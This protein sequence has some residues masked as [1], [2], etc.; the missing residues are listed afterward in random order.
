MRPWSRTTR[1]IRRFSAEEVTTTSER[2][3]PSGSHAI[4]SRAVETIWRKVRLYY[5]LGLH[6]AIARCIRHRG[7]VILD[8]AIGHARGNGPNE[9]TSA[10][11]VL[12]TPDT[13]FNIFS[14]TKPVTAMLAL[15]LVERGELSLDDRVADFIDGFERHGKQGVRIRHLLNHRAGLWRTP[16]HCAN[17]Q[18]LPHWNKIVE[19]MRDLKPESPPG[20]ELAYHA[21]TAGFILAE[22]IQQVTGKSLRTSLHTEIRKPLGFNSCTFGVE[23][24]SL[25]DVAVDSVTGPRTPHAISRILTESLGVDLPGLARV[26]N[27]PRY[28]T[29]VVPSGNLMSTPNEACRFFECLRRGGELDG[30]RVFRPDTVRLATRAQ[31]HRELDR[32]IRFP[33]RYGLGFMLGDEPFSLYGHETPHA[34]GHLGFSQILLWCDPER[35]LSVAFINTGKP[36]FTL[37]FV[38]WRDI[39]NTIAAEIPRSRRLR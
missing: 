30:T 36:L 22:V 23:E 18:I 32:V 34:F 11:R 21:L 39:L 25:S 28:R 14:A 7:Q 19:E 5:G 10:P 17:V 1:R 24:R 9:S 12:A 2:E 38:V 35:E 31:N 20:K 8:R 6:P 33:M 26:S 13:V 16:A 27:D 29:S 37:E 4:S 15:R 3:T